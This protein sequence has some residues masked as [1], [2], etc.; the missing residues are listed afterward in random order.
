MKYKLLQLHDIVNLELDK[1]SYKLVNG[2][3]PTPLIK[4]ANSKGGKKIHRSNK[5]QEL[6][7]HT[8]AHLNTL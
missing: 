6:A 4:L 7:K 5:K 3:L 1:F 2:I 8:E